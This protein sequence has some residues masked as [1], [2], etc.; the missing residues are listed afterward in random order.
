MEGGQLINYVGTI[1]IPFV[2]L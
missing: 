2:Q 1:L